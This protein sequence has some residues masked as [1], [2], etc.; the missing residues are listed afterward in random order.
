VNGLGGIIK[1]LNIGERGK[2]YVNYAMVALYIVTVVY[3]TI[4][5]V[6]VARIPL[7]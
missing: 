5:A 4:L 7:P 6:L 2:A 1:D 3:G